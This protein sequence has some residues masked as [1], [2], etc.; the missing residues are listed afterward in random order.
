MAGSYSFTP[1]LAPMITNPVSE[2]LAK[3]NHTTWKAQVT[4][5]M[6][7]ARLEGYLTGKAV[8]P[9]VEINGK[10]GD[11]IS[12]PAYEDWLASDQHV[13]T[14]LLSSVSKEILAQ[15]AAKQSAAE[16]WTIIEMMFVSKIRAHTVNMRLAL[17]TAQKGSLT[18]TKY[19]TKMRALSDEMAAAGWPLED[20]E[21]VEYILTGLDDE[22]DSVIS[23]ILARSKPVSVSEL[24][25]QLL[26]FETRLDLRSNHNNSS[27]F[28]TNAAKRHGRGGPGRFGR[29]TRGGRNS[30]APTQR[31]SYNSSNNN[32]RQG[33][34]NTRRNSNNGKS[35]DFPLCQVCLKT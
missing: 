16:A 3:H 31:R 15:I 17:A 8:K 21:L 19:V 9:A 30:N 20:E 25:S 18:V 12:N 7:G 2:K 28:S 11:N 10:D 13:L 26:P 35:D 22:Y 34:S 33:S 1:G 6:P 14:F 4:A 23:S 24:Y 27:G 32:F 29:G 5:T